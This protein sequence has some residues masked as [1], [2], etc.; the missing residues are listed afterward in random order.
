VGTRQLVGVN[1]KMC[2][3]EGQSFN[4]SL[5][6]SLN[7]K[8]HRPNSKHSPKPSESSPYSKERAIHLIIFQELLSK[9][10]EEIDGRCKKGSDRRKEL[11]SEVF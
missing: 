7:I 2:K 8:E 11:V 9:L 1:W 4:T 5:S 6:T 10:E 3:N